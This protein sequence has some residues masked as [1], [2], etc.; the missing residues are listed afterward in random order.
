MHTSAHLLKLV[1]DCP[2]LHKAND[3]PELATD[4]LPDLLTRPSGTRPMPAPRVKVL[5]TPF[6]TRVLRGAK[7]R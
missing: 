7:D 4:C 3:P 2:E 6:Q 5:P 1:T